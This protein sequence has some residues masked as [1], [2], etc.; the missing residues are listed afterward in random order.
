MVIRHRGLTAQVDL[1]DIFG[2]VIGKGGK[3]SLKQL[4]AGQLRVGHH[5]GP[6][7]GG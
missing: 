2:L 3:D 1:H 7:F 5:T 6:V 4:F